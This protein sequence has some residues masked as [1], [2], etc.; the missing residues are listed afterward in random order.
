M[1]VLDKEQLE[2]IAHDLNNPL[3]ALM[4]NLGYISSVIGYNPDAKEAVQDCIL[5]Q[6][7]LKRLVENLNALA[8]LESNGVVL[9]EPTPVSALLTSVEQKM[10][11]HAEPSEV[12]L[13]VRCPS[14]IGLVNGSAKFL[15]LALENLVSTSL[16]HSPASTTIELRGRAISSDLVG[17]AV[18][19]EGPPVPEDLRPLVLKKETQIKLKI[20]QPGARYGR[21]FGLYVAAL[22]AESCSGSLEIGEDE[23]NRC[24]F[25]LRLPAA[26]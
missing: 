6:Q 14:D 10:K 11:E 23:R 1:A 5:T 21:G 4:A 7:A 24:C 22:I 3:S 2:L 26:S 18:L 20:P 25:E 16:V 12:G 17:L 19:D 15:T 13:V 8:R 9:S